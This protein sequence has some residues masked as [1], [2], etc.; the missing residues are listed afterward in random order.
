MNFWHDRVEFL[1]HADEFLGQIV[2][3]LCLDLRSSIEAKARFGARKSEVV[4]S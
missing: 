4:T 1:F 3:V 2:M